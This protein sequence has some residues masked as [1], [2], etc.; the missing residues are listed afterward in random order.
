M[1]CG[2]LRARDCTILPLFTVLWRRNEFESGGTCQEKDFC[3]APPL[4]YSVG[5]VRIGERYRDGQYSLISFF[6]AILL[7]TVPPSAQPFVKLGAPAPCTLWS[8]QRPSDC[9]LL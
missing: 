7:L 4:F 3:R 1:C 9:T 5:Y 8:Q 6:F 2:D